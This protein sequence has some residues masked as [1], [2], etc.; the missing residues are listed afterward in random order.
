MTGGKQSVAAWYADIPEDSEYAVYVSYK[1]FPNSTEDAHYTVNYSGGTK[2]FRVNQTMGGG[3]WIYLGTFPLTKGYSDTEPIVTLTNLSEKGEGM[4]ITA[5]AVKIGGG[6]GNIARSDRRSDIYY[7]PSTPEV[8]S[9]TASTPTATSDADSKTG[10][11]TNS[12]SGQNRAEPE[13]EEESDT[14]PLKKRKMKLTK[15]TKSM[16]NR[17]S[18]ELP[19]ARPETLR[20][21]NR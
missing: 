5:D 4:V 18:E 9:D 10:S 8:S 7:D 3:T 16:T 11:G 20:A 17:G 1:S 19:D 15:L 2:E 6:M 13:G 14:D 21:A 12:L